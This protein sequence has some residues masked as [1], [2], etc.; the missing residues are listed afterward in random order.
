MGLVVYTDLDG[1]LLDHATYSYDEAR[2][3][4]DAL[5]EKG[6]PLILCSSK[7][8]AE[9][10]PLWYELE[11][12]HP[13]I[14]EN[15]GGLF[16]SRENPLAQGPGWQD[17]GDGWRVLALGMPVA[18]VRQ[19]FCVFKERFKAKG[20]FDLSDH[21][22]AKLTGLSLAEA[23]LARRR[24][25]NEPVLL[26]HAREQE[27]DFT[28]AAGR[29]G[30]EVAKGGRFYHLLGGADKGKAVRLL[31]DFYRG[32]DPGLITAALGDSPND[33]PM[34][35]AVDH[36]FL[37]ARFDGGHADIRLPGLVKSPRIGPR[38][39]NRAVLDL[40]SRSV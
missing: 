27:A 11:L 20:F 29:S 31:N 2:P 24:E 16:A 8:R 13:F 30:L 37:V 25:F 15:G 6:V 7:T 14:A 35:A 28:A 3:A 23:A 32:K 5:H 12:D 18:E 19:K 38:G 36:P 4:L 40:L 1:T 17:A 21:E 26:P 9:M 34:L 39:W 33:T 10:I 22:V